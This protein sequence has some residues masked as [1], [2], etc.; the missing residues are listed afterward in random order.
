M[1]DIAK[2]ADG[3]TEAQKHFIINRPEKGWTTYLPSS[4]RREYRGIII[5]KGYCENALS[6][7][8]QA[9]RRHLL[10]QEKKGGQP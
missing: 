10:D 4:E 9:L 6:R 5:R 2:L 8:G 1:T 3:L 7:K